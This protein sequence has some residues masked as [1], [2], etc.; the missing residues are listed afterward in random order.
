M[1]KRGHV[2]KQNMVIPIVLTI[3]IT[4]FAV[5]FRVKLAMVSEN[6][7]ENIEAVTGLTRSQIKSFS[8]AELRSYVEKKGG[9]RLT[10]VSEFPF[11]GRGNVLRDNLMTSSQIND[12]VDSILGLK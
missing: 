6:V 7:I 3:N 12:D 4:I 11:I 1:T 9:R 10:F 2:R 5:L 8:P